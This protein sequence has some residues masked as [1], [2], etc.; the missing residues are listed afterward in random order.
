M[1]ETTN[2]LEECFLEQLRALPRSSILILN[3]QRFHQVLQALRLLTN[4]L[5]VGGNSFTVQI[6][7][8][9]EHG[10]AAVR[11]EAEDLIVDTPILFAA[12]MIHADNFEIYPL[13]NGSYRL[14]LQFFDVLVPVWEEGRE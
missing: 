7:L 14:A 6:E 2:Y 1:D 3:P 5:R 8:V 12:S 11:V 9:P 10:A 4:C 13:L